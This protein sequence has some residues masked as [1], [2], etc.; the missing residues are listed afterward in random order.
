MQYPS[1]VVF[2]FHKNDENAIKTENLQ[3]V[4]V[5][6]CSAKLIL[7]YPRVTRTIFVGFFMYSSYTSAFVEGVEEV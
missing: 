5:V 1:I 6:Q 4:Q 7:R 2:F 3:I